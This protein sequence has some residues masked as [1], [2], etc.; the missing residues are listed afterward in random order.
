MSRPGGPPQGARRLQVITNSF[1][2]TGLPKKA[3]YQYD[4]ELRCHV[5]TTRH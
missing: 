2:I 5:V 4:G 3:Y 1:K